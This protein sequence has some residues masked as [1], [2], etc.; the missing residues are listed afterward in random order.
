MAPLWP[1][2]LI[3]AVAPVFPP[4]P[5][6]VKLPFSPPSKHKQL[7]DGSQ[8]VQLEYIFRCGCWEL[9]LFG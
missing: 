9:R 6:V 4:T 3:L 7:A 2:W 5:R 8:V 1:L